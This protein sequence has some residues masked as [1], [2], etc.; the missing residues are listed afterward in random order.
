MIVVKQKPLEWVLDRL[1]GYRKVLVLGCGSCATVCFAG[2]ER[3]VELS[4]RS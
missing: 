4:S 1:D 2:G 3:E